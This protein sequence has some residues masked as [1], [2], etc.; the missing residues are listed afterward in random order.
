MEKSPLVGENY[1]RSLID[2]FPSP[3]FIVDQD[4]VVH[5]A[6]HASSLLFASDIPSSLHRL[7]GDSLRCVHADEAPEG[8]GSTPWCPECIIR[9]LTKAVLTGA[10]AHKQIASMTLIR[11]GQPKDLRFLVSGAPFPYAGKEYILLT[12]ED[13]T[14]LTELRKIIPI[15]SY[16]RKVR[17]DADYWQQVEEYF[18]KYS[19]LRFSHGLCPDCIEKHYADDL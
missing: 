1:L 9:Q 5:D 16:C 8:C 10:A 18:V 19:N 7:C 11:D 2:A 12:F 4:L 14:E 13:V 3:V 6:N 15:C 17:D